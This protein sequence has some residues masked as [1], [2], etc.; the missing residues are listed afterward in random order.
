VQL[1]GLGKLKKST[2]S[3]FDPVNLPA[4]STVPQPTTLPRVSSLHNLKTQQN[5]YNEQQAYYLLASH[6]FTS[7]GY[8]KGQMCSNYFQTQSHAAILCK[9]MATHYFQIQSHVIILCS[10]IGYSNTIIGY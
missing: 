8:I 9:E 2:T 5:S 6:T 10:F 4:C 3:G 7:H 1:K